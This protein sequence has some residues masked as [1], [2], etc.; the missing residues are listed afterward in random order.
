MVI[1]RIG[2]AAL[3]VCPVV[4]D[5]VIV[6]AL[7]TGDT[8]V[9]QQ[10]EDAIRMGAKGTEVAETIKGFH[11]KP[12]CI[13]QGRGQRKVVAI[14]PAKDGDS[15]QLRHHVVHWKHWR[16]SCRNGNK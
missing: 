14:N 5:R 12:P 2:V 15:A 8:P 16:R 1:A 3:A 11:A 10:R 9:P 4:A 6:I 13:L 7:D